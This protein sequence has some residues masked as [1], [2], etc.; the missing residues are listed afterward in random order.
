M[1]EE[2]PAPTAWITVVETSQGPSRQVNWAQMRGASHEPL[3]TADQ[4]R[5][6]IQQERERIERVALHLMK[7]HHW[8]A[9]PDIPDDVADWELFPVDVSCEEGCVDVLI[10]PAA[11]IRKG[12][13][14]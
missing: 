9:D 7:Y 14:P 11:A 4:M 6:A 12:E 8:E 3:Y 10:V 5:A 2:L 13:T 1:S